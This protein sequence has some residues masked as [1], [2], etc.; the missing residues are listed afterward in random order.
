MSEVFNF[1]FQDKNHE[2]QLDKTD[3]SQEKLLSIQGRDYKIFGSEESVSLLKS[4]I[5]T[6]EPS[7]FESIHN[8]KKSLENLESHV[9]I[10]TIAIEILLEKSPNISL[11]EEINTFLQNAV[12]GMHFRGVVLVT[13][14]GNE[15]LKQGYGQKGLTNLTTFHIASI[16]K[17]FTAAMILELHQQKKLSIDD[18]INNLLPSKFQCKEWSE[19]K[20]KHLLSHTSG[21]PNFNPDPG[22]Q[23]EY[24]LDEL[25]QIFK[26]KKLEFQPGT[27]VAYCNSGYALLGAIIEEIY[28]KPFSE[29]IQERILTRFDMKSSGFG[30]TYNT[31]TAA[32]GYEIKPNENGIGT[33]LVPVEKQE[34]FLSKAYA[35]GAL[36]SCLDDLQKYDV[37]LY[38]D[39][40]L[41]QETRDL[42]FSPIYLPGEALPTMMGLGFKIWND[43][44]LGLIVSKEG[45]IPGFNTIIQRY[46]DSKSCI[47]VLANNGSLNAEEKIGMEIEGMLL[48][49]SKK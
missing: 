3:N 13:Q 6:L 27:N 22:E 29:C 18:S 40:F 25:I 38:D 20:V 42:M 19:I 36:Y 45:A 1:F 46:V 5:P 15:I 34:S 30:A 8:F 7:S 37:A 14:D 49:H 33:S 43:E 10:G 9:K 32:Q 17:S 41:S 11:K 21:I 44:K 2:I 35:G 48:K 31:E 47:V 24:Q 16:T 28:G 12:E 39:S 4:L 26:D 23:K